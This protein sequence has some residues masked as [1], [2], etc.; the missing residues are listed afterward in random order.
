MIKSWQTS[1]NQANNAYSKVE[2]HAQGRG[3]LRLSS[4]LAAGLKRQ[5]PVTL[6]AA[7]KREIWEQY[8]A[9]GALVFPS[10][11]HICVAGQGQAAQDR[12]GRSQ[13]ASAPTL[14]VICWQ[15]AL[16]GMRSARPRKEDTRSARWKMPLSCGAATGGQGAA[17]GNKAGKQ[18]GSQGIIM[19][20]SPAQ[21]DGTGRNALSH[22]PAL[23]WVPPPARP[24]A[25][26]P[27]AAGGQSAPHCRPRSRGSRS[28]GST[29][30]RTLRQA[31]P[32]QQVAGA[33]EWSIAAGQGATPI[34]L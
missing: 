15:S 33:H 19:A 11:E 24:S 28:A 12:P 21:E 25:R 10:V 30:G 32:A 17:V 7:G 26:G 5:H 16:S 1:A 27:G 18:R 6:C 20:G 4:I 3:E 9:G 31:D 8:A 34:L 13:P 23:G 22:Q 2:Q 29:A 14:A